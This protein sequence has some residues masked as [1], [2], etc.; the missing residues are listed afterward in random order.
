MEKDP[1]AYNGRGLIEI[2]LVD[3]NGAI[4]DFDDAIDKDSLFSD[5]YLNRWIA[6]LRLI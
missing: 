6:K 5:A 3:V 4:K 2:Q 1:I